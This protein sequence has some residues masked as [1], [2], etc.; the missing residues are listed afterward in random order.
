MG[1]TGKSMDYININCK[2]EVTLVTFDNWVGYV[3]VWVP[4]TLGL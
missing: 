4:S 1:I 3:W 2:Y